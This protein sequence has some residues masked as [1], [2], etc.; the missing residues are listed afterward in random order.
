MRRRQVLAL[1]IAAVAGCTGSNPGAGG[2]D[3]T[4]SSVESTATTTTTT[5]S[6]STTTVEPCSTDIQVER[7]PDRPDDLSS[8]A[9]YVVSRVERA[10]ASSHLDPDGYFHFWLRDVVTRDAET[11]VWVQAKAEVDYSYS[12]DGEDATTVHAHY[13]YPVTYRLTDRRVVRAEAG[14]GPTGTVVCW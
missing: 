9:E 6:T 1:S 13:R 3:V 12:G 4:T 11:G 14:Q 10:V 2:S 5:T 7:P 8:G